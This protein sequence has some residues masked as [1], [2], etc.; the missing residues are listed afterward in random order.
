M[1][2]FIF[3]GGFP[4]GHSMFIDQ[5]QVHS[6]KQQCR[7]FGRHSRHIQTGRG[8]EMGVSVLGNTLVEFP[9]RLLWAVGTI[10]ADR[11]TQRKP[12][13]G[14]HVLINRCLIFWELI[15]GVYTWWLP[16]IPLAL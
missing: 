13:I 15:V 2:K 10:R 6:G 5:P 9:Q 7:F 14:L 1:G 4:D 16:A 8:I 3:F 11:E 12:T